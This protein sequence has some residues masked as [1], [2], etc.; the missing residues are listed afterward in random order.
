MAFP[1]PYNP[2]PSRY[3]SM[4]YRRSEVARVPLLIHQPSYSSLNRWIE[5]QPTLP[6]E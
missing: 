5:E 2:V 6:Y 1:V 4:P 3:D